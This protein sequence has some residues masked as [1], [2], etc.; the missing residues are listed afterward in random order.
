MDQELYHYG[1]KGMKWGVRRAQKKAAKKELKT[2][3]KAYRA[4]S[5][6][7]NRTSQYGTN[8]DWIDAVKNR[9]KFVSDVTKKKGEDFTKKMLRQNSK[10]SLK[11]IAGGAAVGI[12]LSYLS[13]MGYKRR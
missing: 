9:D 7:I 13:S 5:A 10:E 2:Y 11:I 12:G 6:D 4:L 1:V 3:T 8:Q